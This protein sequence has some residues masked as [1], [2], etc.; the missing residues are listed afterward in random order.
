VESALVWPNALCF[1]NEL[2]GGTSRGYESLS[3]SNYDWGQGLPELADWAR[4]N[5]L[6]ELAVWYFGTDPAVNL[7]PFCNVGASVMSSRDERQLRQAM[8]GRYL[9]VGV[10][11]LYGSYATPENCPILTWLR[12]Q[13]PVARTQTF[14]IF[15]LNGAESVRRTVVAIP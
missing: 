5:G 9:A 12:K 13:V 2:W 7:P 6:P 1:T 14:L 4:S 15:D 10:T 11:L 8:P 3:D